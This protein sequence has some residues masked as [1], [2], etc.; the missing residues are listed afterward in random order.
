MIWSCANSD[1]P[2][3]ENDRLL[4]SVYNRSLYW[5][6][7]APMLLPGM[8]S[9][10]ST[11]FINT[12]VEGWVRDNLLLHEAEKNIPKDL[13]IDGL[14]RDYRASL[15][16]YNYENM[17]VELQLDST[18]TEDAYRTYYE[19]HKADFLLE[20]PLLRC[21]FVK[22]R[23]ELDG[24]NELRQWW[25]KVDEPEFYDQVLAYANQSADLFMLADSSWYELE[26]VVQE[27]P[28]NTLSEYNYSSRRE[29]TASDEQFNYL[30]RIFDTR[31]VGDQAPLDY[32]RDQARKVILHKRKIDLL[33]K[34]KEE[35]YEK[36]ERGNNFK[37][38]TY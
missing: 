21:F 27:L 7:L 31:K 16:L 13:D 10:D 1:S 8:T 18:I 35:I 11:R 17:L 15:I 38:Y 34:R 25:R 32:V 14:V 5:S 28:T 37:I 30:V 2:E 22:V 9:E 29:I 12:F 36:E 6:E 33:N 4:A 26:T 19:E 24:W 23:K 3:G 20:K